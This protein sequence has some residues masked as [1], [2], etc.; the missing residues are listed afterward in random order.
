MS[1]DTSCFSL[2]GKV[3][4]VTGAARG[5]GASAAEAL[6]AHG[7]TVMLTDVL[8]DE[9]AETAA[10]LADKGYGAAY[11]TQDVTSESRWEDVVSETIATF[12]GL[13]V[14]VN[15]A[16][17]EVQAL[18]TQTTLENFQRIMAVNADGVF[19]GT[20]EAI[21]AMSPGGSAGEG[22]SISNG[23]DH[24]G[25]AMTDIDTPDSGQSID[26]FLAIGV[27]YVKTLASCDDVATL[28]IERGKIRPGVKQVIFVGLLDR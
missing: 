5:L 2:Q 14:L 18:V 11:L 24:L 6:A 12:G 19:L 13:D 7:A 16:G 23:I 20:R 21:R 3:A 1:Y 25:V 9:G 28:F 10:A 22:G 17:I 4:L 15:N 8:V 26:V 27:E